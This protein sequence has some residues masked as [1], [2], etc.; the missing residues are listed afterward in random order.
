[1]TASTVTVTLIRNKILHFLLQWSW[2]QPTCLWRE[3]PVGE[4]QNWLSWGPLS[5]RSQYTAG[6][7]I[8]RVPWRLQ[9]SACPDGRWPTSHTP[10]PPQQ[11]SV[12]KLSHIIF[13]L[14]SRHIWRPGSESLASQ[15][16]VDTGTL[17]QKNREQG[18][19]RRTRRREKMARRRAQHPG[20][21]LSAEYK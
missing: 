4:H 9:L 13:S 2:D 11:I 21:A 18:R 1:M 14:A 5:C 15:Y 16:Q 10:E 6:W 12:G 20:P 7:R 3:P 8:S 17:T 19:V